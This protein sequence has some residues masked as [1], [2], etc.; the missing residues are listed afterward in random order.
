L[1]S[2]TGGIP[3]LVTHEEHALLVPPG[4]ATALAGGM[5]RLCRDRQL[6][7]DLLRN[8]Q[9]RADTEFN[10]ETQMSATLRAYQSAWSKLQGEG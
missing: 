1:A 4:D 10:F 7:E 3:E 8:A 2:D 9:R 5:I 6:A